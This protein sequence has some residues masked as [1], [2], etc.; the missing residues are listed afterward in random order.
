MKTFCIKL[1]VV[2]QVTL[3]INQ[4]KDHSKRS[5]ELGTYSTAGAFYGISGVRE[6][7]YAMR[8]GNELSHASVLNSLHGFANS[9]R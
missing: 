4:D 1:L 5:V 6:F 9:T 3:V 2:L 7:T 8:G